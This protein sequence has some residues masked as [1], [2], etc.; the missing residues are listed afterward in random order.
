VL[1][2]LSN[3]VDYH[4]AAEE[5]VM[6]STG[7]ER[8]EQ[9]QHWHNTFRKEVASL[10]EQARTEGVSKGL[11]LKLS[12]AIENWLLDHIRITD[13]QLAQ[14]LV[15]Q[16]GLRVIELPS[17]KALVISGK[18]SENIDNFEFRK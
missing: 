17:P 14:H 6:H 2:F 9:H 5:N 3:Y 11:K 4:F 1:T 15:H 7:Y 10:V 8:A 13:R 16:S 12:F 18:I